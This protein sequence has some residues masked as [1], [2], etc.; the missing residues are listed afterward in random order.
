M[1]SLVVVNELRIPR[2]LNPTSF[3]TSELLIFCD[4]SSTAYGCVAHLRTETGTD[5]HVRFVAS[6]AKVAPIKSRTIPQLEL[7]AA[8]LGVKFGQ[9]I[10]ID[11]ATVA[12]FTDSTDTLLWIR[13]QGSNFK[14]YVK[15]K[16]YEIQLESDASQWRH[17]PTDCNP[18]DIC[19]RGA[20]PDALHGQSLW[21]QGPKCLRLPK[22]EWISTASLP[23]LD[24]PLPEM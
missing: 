20:H 5:V 14:P 17:V 21:I 12:Y 24:H 3:P 19:S 9:V 1:N 23:H 15:N 18:A 11:P 10:S 6:K 2:C 16:I 4:A 13:G 8:A 7:T 22:S